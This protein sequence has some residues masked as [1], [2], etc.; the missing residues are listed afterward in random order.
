MEVPCEVEFASSTDVALTALDNIVR[1]AE[2]L[3]LPGAQLV[4]EAPLAA[5]RVLVEALERAVRSKCE[6]LMIKRLD[7]PY[8]PS[9]KRSGIDPLVCIPE[10]RNG[11]SLGS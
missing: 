6:G 10:P 1:T 2:T 4:N 8:Q 9:T 5:R 3:S 11:C 7:A